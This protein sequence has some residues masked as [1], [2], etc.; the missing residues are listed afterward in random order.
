MIIKKLAPESN[1]RRGANGTMTFDHFRC[2]LWVPPIRGGWSFKTRDTRYVPKIIPAATS[3]VVMNPCVRDMPS[4]LII[5]PFVVY[6]KIAI[7]LNS[8]NKKMSARGEVGA[9]TILYPILSSPAGSYVAKIRPVV[10]TLESISLKF[11]G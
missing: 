1:E 6:N 7:Y 5:L 3:I 11:S 9:K 8:V 10:P 2:T 4:C